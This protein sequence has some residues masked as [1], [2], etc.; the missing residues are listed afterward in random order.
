MTQSVRRALCLLALAA[1]PS[2][3]VMAVTRP[4]RAAPATAP[5][6]PAAAA[7]SAPAPAA[8][9]A[10]AAVPAAD[11]ARAQPKFP[12]PSLYPIEWELKFDPKTPRRIV[13]D[14]PRSGKRNAYWYLAYT[15]TNPTDKPIEFTPSFQL[16]SQNSKSF[17]PVRSDL[18][19]P[20]A[21]FNAIFNRE[22]NKFLESARKIQGTLNPG[23]EQARDGVA[24]WP[25]PQSRMGK[26][27]IFVGGLSG[28]YAILKK[29]DGQFVPI[30]LKKAAEEL[31]GVPES[32][33]ITLRKTLQLSFHVPGDEVRP[34]EDPVI[35]KGQKWVMR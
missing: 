26:F 17:D 29:K 31:K 9:A 24:I 10:P 1:V 23:V 20:A 19:I 14:D 5:A 22:G 4:S 12:E 16:L 11:T 18:G 3:V 34:G 13:V 35:K 7:P 30:D 27:D 33:R 8:P 2:A 21:V 6:A 15:V 25:E 28:E 32:D